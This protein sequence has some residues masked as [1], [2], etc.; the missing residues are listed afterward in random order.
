MSFNFDINK[1]AE[2]FK[3]EDIEKFKDVNGNI[4]NV[5]DTFLFEQED[6]DWKL[7]EDLKTKDGFVN[8]LLS[9]KEKALTED[10]LGTIYDAISSMDGTD[11]MSEAELKALIYSDPLCNVNYFALI[12][13][14]SAVVASARFA[15]SS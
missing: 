13:F 7:N 9:S 10:Q 4:N 12:L 8:N 2:F 6:G 14:K 3:K 5:E 1:M 11:R 15:I